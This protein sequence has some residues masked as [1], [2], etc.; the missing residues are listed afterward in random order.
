MSKAVITLDARLDFANAG[1]LAASILEYSG[2]DLELDASGVTHLGALGLQVI[3][4]A[5]KSWSGTGQTLEISGCS[6]DTTDQLLLLGFT[7]EDVCEW[8]GEA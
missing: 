1:A 5:A 4:S 6:N 7:P 3:R 2:E 8:G